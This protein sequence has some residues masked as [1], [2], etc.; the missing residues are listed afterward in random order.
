MVKS[1]LFEV[2]YKFM[3]ESFTFSLGLFKIFHCAEKALQQTS[4]QVND[5]CVVVV[6]VF[7]PITTVL[8]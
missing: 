4:E 3:N 8:L 7:R 1:L 6:N 2:N 5:C